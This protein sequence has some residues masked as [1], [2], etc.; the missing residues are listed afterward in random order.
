MAVSRSGYYN[1]SAGKSFVQ[2]TEKRR[3]AEKVKRIFYRH[4]R[5]YGS[6]RIK[7]QLCD[8][9]E[10]MGRYQI[11]SLMKAENLE[12]IRAKRFVPRTTDSK[13]KS[14]A[15]PNLL[16]SEDNQ[17]VEKGQMIIGDI[18]Y[19]PLSNGRWCYLAIWQDKFTRR[20][21]GWAVGARITDDLVIVAFEKAVR[22]GQVKRGAIVHTDRGSQYVS[23][24]F[25]RL[26]KKQGLRQSMSAKGNCYDNAQAESFFSRFKTELV[27]DGLFDGV[28]QARSEA[29][30]YIEGYYNRIRKHSSLGYKSPLEFE[31]ELRKKKERTRVSFVS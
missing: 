1:W 8:E 18:T 9:G 2:S 4:R 5:R 28:E 22:S 6:R 10:K 7:A 21:V 27:E 25:R 12:A 29:F 23:K 14:L 19:L 16:K 11:R 17:P 3:R 13:H 30:S 26:L 15:S 31:E 20:I 24:D